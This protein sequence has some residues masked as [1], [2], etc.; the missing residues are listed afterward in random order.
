M[1]N[2]EVYSHRVFGFWKLV[3]IILHKTNMPVVVGLKMSARPALPMPE[4][5]T[6]DDDACPTI[7][8]TER[9]E[10]AIRRFFSHRKDN[11]SYFFD[12]SASSLHCYAKNAIFGW[13][14]RG[15]ARDFLTFCMNAWDPSD[16]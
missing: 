15:M 8:G 4:R 5:G 3:L 9:A 10:L 14:S 7:V 16:C 12:W 6:H 2:T 11:T 1:I 13:M